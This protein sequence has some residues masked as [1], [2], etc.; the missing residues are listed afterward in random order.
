MRNYA[1]PGDTV[2]IRFDLGVDGC[3]GSVGWY[4]DNVD[5]CATS[6][7]DMV[8]SDDFESGDDSEWSRTV[9]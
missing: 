7:T 6:Q 5:L 9:P 3:N 8:F 1:G 2:E 4:V